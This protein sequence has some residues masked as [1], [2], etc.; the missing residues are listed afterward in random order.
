MAMDNNKMSL[1][2]YNE[3]REEIKIKRS[4]D[5]S[6]DTS[7]QSSID[8]DKDIP[9]FQIKSRKLRLIL[10]KVTDENAERL[11]VDLV[12]GF[13]YNTKLLQELLKLLFERATSRNF[14]DLYSSLCF[15]FSMRMKHHNPKVHTAFKQLL[16]SRCAAILTISDPS[17]VPLAKFV[18]LLFKLNLIKNSTI[19]QFLDLA[20][21]DS[22]TEAQLEAGCSMIKQLSPYLVATTSDRIEKLI[23]SLSSINCARHSKKI[24]FL[25]MDVMD[26]KNSL[27]TPVAISQKYCGSAWKDGKKTGKGVS[28]ANVCEFQPVQSRQM[29]RILKQGVSEEVKTA[30]REAVCEFMGG[31]VS[32]SNCREIFQ[33]NHNKERQLINQIFKYA[34]TK[35]NREHEFIKIC[36]MIIGISEEIA[37]KEAIETGLT[38]TVEAIHDIQ[39][40]S[41]MAPQ[42]LVFV[43]NHLHDTGIIEN[44]NY[45]LGHFNT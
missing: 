26:N 14:A 25:V 13:N 38:Y 44:T 2:L 20:I 27:L 37:K 16:K 43:I 33:K 40:D 29:K 34:L 17:V 8:L 15:S 23:L 45:L 41:P 39:L 24:E 6:V 19:Y 4:E 31:K 30:L 3:V 32:M 42:N 35:Y 12:T 11:V 22:S 28:F 10:N 5:I 9:D 18:G 1:Q 21:S 36:E 7:D